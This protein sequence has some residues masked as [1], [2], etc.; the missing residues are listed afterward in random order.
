MQNPIQTY[1]VN[2]KGRD[3]VIGD[4]HGSFQLFIKLLED[5]KFDAEVDRMF[6]VGDLV[7]RGEDSLNCL[8]LYNEPWFHSVI[9]NHEQMMAECFDGGYMGQFWFRNGGEWGFEHYKNW[10][11]YQRDKHL[12]ADGF[13][14]SPETIEFIGLLDIVHELPF[15]MTINLRDGSK[16]HVIHAEL[17]PSHIIT[18]EDLASPAKVRELA[19]VQ[20]HDGD[21]F[22]WGR[23][24]F[25]SFYKTDLS[26]IAKNI[27]IVRNIFKDHQVNDK[28]SK[29]ISGHTILQRPMTI[30]GQTNIDTCAYDAYP[31]SHGSMRNWCALTCLEL[32]EWRF[33]QCTM[34]EFRTVDPLIINT[35]DL[36]SLKEE[37][38]GHA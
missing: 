26:N 3:F 34:K 8:R 28:L 6:S 7:D 2:S 17:P 27:R 37:E 19:T 38:N 24:K 13:Q 32:N 33:H 12:E 9:A 10:T 22:V 31:D 11:N 5:I 36:N 23:H 18:D 20:S 4:L 14:L 15:I 1:E 29:I 30:L 21:F 35:S 25:Y 16:C